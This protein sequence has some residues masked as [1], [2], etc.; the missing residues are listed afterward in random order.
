M[1]SFEKSAQNRRANA[2]KLN[3]SEVKDIPANYLRTTRPHFPGKV[4]NTCAARGLYFIVH[5]PSG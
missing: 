3:V 2:F 5:E 1:L 4:A